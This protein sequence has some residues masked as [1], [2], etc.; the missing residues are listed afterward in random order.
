MSKL[1]LRKPYRFDP[2]SAKAY[3]LSRSK[4]DL[5]VEC[6]RCFYLDRK[7]G[8]RR[9]GRM[10]FNLNNA[11]DSLLKKEFD[12]YRESGTAHPIMRQNGIDAVPYAH[13]ELEFWRE[14]LSGG[15]QFLHQETNFL[16]TGAPDD[17]WVNAAGELSVVDYKATRALS[18][19]SLDSGEHPGY[20]RQLDFYSWLLVKMGF[21]V[22]KNSYFVVAETRL[23]RSALNHALEFDLNLIRYTS[24]WSWIEPVLIEL[25]ACLMSTNVPEASLDC[26]YC[27]YVEAHE[28]LQSVPQQIS[29]L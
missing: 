15:L 20:Q 22:S 7:L 16:L 12:H 24:D 8:L 26:D 23:N 21:E 11:V 29:L 13:A 9:P 19:G 5:F 10:V 25:K 4:V 1:Y 14:P 2:H 27:N 6:P 18:Q 28:Y 17:L 3:K